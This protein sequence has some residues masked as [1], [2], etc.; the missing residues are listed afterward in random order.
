MYRVSSVYYPGLRYTEGPEAVQVDVRVWR[1]DAHTL[2]LLEVERVPR[3]L[4]GLARKVYHSLVEEYRMHQGNVRW[5]VFEQ[6][7]GKIQEARFRRGFGLIETRSVGAEELAQLLTE[8][9]A[10]AQLAQLL[11]VGR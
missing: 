5:L 4:G 10:R 1:R 11:G 2:V 7:S 8:F 6:A 9:G 3:V